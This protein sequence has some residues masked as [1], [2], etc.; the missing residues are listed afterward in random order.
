MASTLQKWVM[1]AIGA[2]YAFISSTSA[3][4]NKTNIPKAIQIQHVTQIAV[5]EEYNL[6]LVI[7][8]KSL[9]AYHLDIVCP[10]DGAPQLINSNRKAPQ[11]LSGS[12]D[13]GFFA[14]GRMKDRTLVFYKKRDVGGQSNFRVSPPQNPFDH[15]MHP[16]STNPPLT[17]LSLIHI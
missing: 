14:A 9:I 8:D 11:K 16:H 10:T 17:H 1:S 3:Y 2:E 12:K 15:Y 6:M 5:L 4:R 13:V 7:A